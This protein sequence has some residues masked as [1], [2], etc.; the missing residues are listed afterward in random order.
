M[1]TKREDTP[2]LD[3]MDLWFST[4]EESS[5]DLNYPD[6]HT[7]T[8]SSF[9]IPDE[10]VAAV[11]EP[12]FEMLQD[13]RNLGIPQYTC[14]SIPPPIVTYPMGI[15]G[16]LSLPV[17]YHDGSSFEMPDYQTNA[18]VSFNQS[19]F[20]Q[21][22]G[23]DSNNINTQVFQL[24]TFRPVRN[25]VAAPNDYIT[26]LT[27]ASEANSPDETTS[28]TA[29]E[30][31]PATAQAFSPAYAPRD[32]EVDKAP[33]KH[34]P[35]QPNQFSREHTTAAQKEILSHMGNSSFKYEGH[36]KSEDDAAHKRQA[37]ESLSAQTDRIILSPEMDETFPSCDEQYRRRIK[38][39]FEAICDWT[40]HTLQWRAKMGQQRVREWLNE[41]KGQLE[42][43]G[44]S[45]NLSQL[46][47]DEL[48]PPA[49]KMPPLAQQWQNVIH[50]AMSSI[51][52]ELLCSRILV[53]I[54][55]L[56]SKK[57]RLISEKEEA[58]LAQRGE[59]HVPLWCNNDAH[60]EEF[61]TFEAR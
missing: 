3:T 44:L 34:K 4:E 17:S 1:S 14:N 29:T 21:D 50:H 23:I 57:D 2:C 7:L 59:L 58:M 53:S 27:Q 51:E 39:L 42:T 31:S 48:A 9:H 5:F 45:S 55:S 61:G 46:S 40:S 8:E 11:E 52:I 6:W 20:T 22:L 54:S 18:H 26:P 32:L 35:K 33:R 10:S 16:A 19:S 60:W 56:N 43:A 15:Y 25:E 12:S 24:D 13:Q 28:E 38:E 37:Y 30:G 49:D 47:D 41:K 36:I